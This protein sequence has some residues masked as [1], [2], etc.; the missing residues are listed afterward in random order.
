MKTLLETRGWDHALFIDG[1]DVTSNF[2]LTTRNL[3]YVEILPQQQIN[4]YSILQK[5]LLV[6]TK[7]AIKYLEER[8]HVE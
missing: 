1:A 8:L 2:A 5:D 6:I 7:D 4:V 3:A